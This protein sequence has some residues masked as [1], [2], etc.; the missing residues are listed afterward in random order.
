MKNKLKTI[1]IN[2]IIFLLN[3]FIYQSAFSEIIKNFEI[4]GN[5]R[6]SNETVI[7][8][9]N[10]KIGDNVTKNDLNEA[11]KNLYYTDYF[12]DVSI[13]L[14]DGYL[15]IVLIENPII[16][17]VEIK[18]VKQNNINEKL[19]DITIKLE[20][21]P[22]VEN[23]INDQV[24]L[25]KNTL[26][27][28]GYYFV[29][30]KTSVS[31]NDNNTVDLI[32]DINL[33]EIAKIK[34][35]SFIGN[36]IFRD[37]TLRNVVISEESKFWKFLSNNKFLDQNRISADLKRLNNFYKNRGYYN[38]KIKSTTGII[39]EDKQFELIFNI[40]AG[41]KFFF[42]NL[43]IANTTNYSIDSLKKFQ[44]KFKDLK[45]QKYSKK[46]INNLIDDL[47]QFILRNDF[48][49]INAKFDEIIKENNK[50][51]INIFFDELDQKIVE[52][53][54]IFGN[55]ITDEKVIRNTLIVDEG[56]VYND[57][58]FNKSIQK[59]KAKNIFK[60]VNYET[61]SSDD[62]SKTIDITVE[63]KPTGELFA[64]AGTG[65]TGTSFTAGIKEKNYLGL[66][67]KLD[68]N[69]VVSDDSIKGRFL[70]TNPNYNNSD[71]SI[72][73]SIESSTSD[74]MST[75][76][77]KTSRT[78]FSI[79]TEF[80]QKN[81]LF[82]NLELSNFYEDLETTSSAT[83]I[84]KKQEGNYIENL[85]MYSIK[86]NRLDQDFQ[87]TDGFITNFS[88]SL[89]VY[90]DDLSIENIFTSSLYH[91]LGD[92]LILS[93][94]YFL[95]TINSL[96]DN[97]RISKRVFVPSRRLRGFENGKIGPKDGSQYIGGNYATALNLNTTFPN[98]LFEKENLD[99]NFF[100][101]M[102]NVWEVD[103][104]NS[105]DSNKIRS[106]TGLAVN[107]FSAIGP[108]T[109]SY[110]IPLTDSDTDVTESFRFQIGTSF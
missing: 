19:R 3:F 15:K 65:T 29:D 94:N 109:F 10:L 11:L 96:E 57:V 16:Q 71:K 36:K 12:K 37:N 48:T 34:K 63:E 14:E 83:D 31:I 38:A 101:D 87:P 52:R 46:I 79:G 67:I 80:E 22:F 23:Q 100:I 108:L 25:I 66:G 95:K 88:Q 74:F 64:G 92:N 13:S 4:K 8:F 47:N 27:S 73:T 53:I 32:Y 78:G 104:N 20:K 51:D 40:N 110:A 18:G 86:Y 45:G 5:F 72:K 97:V 93:A 85:L 105:L 21:Y 1:N 91:S 84:V 9:S 61:S 17:S 59:V 42:D 30:L 75:S 43:E 54:N 28:N 58:L 56:D 33:G 90:S 41:E 82:V 44:K 49:L 89:P 103:Y 7:M 62:L 69:L 98:V 50:I 35:I 107:W 106:S 99:L 26:K 68:T 81:D 24:S 6:V 55:F 60:S 39:T 77:Y 76:G 102:A 70:V 2:I